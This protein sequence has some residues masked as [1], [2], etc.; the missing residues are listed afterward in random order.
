MTPSEKYPNIHTA[1]FVIALDNGGI[2]RTRPAY[3]QKADFDAWLARSGCH[4]LYDLDAINTWLGALPKADLETVCVGEMFEMLKLMKGAPNGT[5]A[6]L[7]AYFDE[8]C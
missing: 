7:S 3:Q 2:N 4:A 1:S 5:D 8:V 6:L